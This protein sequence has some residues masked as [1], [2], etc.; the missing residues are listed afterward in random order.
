VNIVPTPLPLATPGA[1]KGRSPPRSNDSLQKMITY[2]DS[3]GG[4]LFAG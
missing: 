2:I 3:T 1:S 4:L